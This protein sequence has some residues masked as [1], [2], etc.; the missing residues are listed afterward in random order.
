[1]LHSNRTLTTFVGGLV[2]AGFLAGCSGRSALL[3]IQTAQTTQAAIAGD[4]AE[5]LFAPDACSNPQ[6]LK[7][8][9]KPGGTYKLQITLKCYLGTQ[10]AGCGTTTWSTKL[11]NKLLHAKF[12]NPADPTT[13]TVTA[14]KTIKLGHY[15]QA[16]TVKCTGVP[17]C[18][19]HA[20]G[21]IWV[22]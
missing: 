3:P 5:H 22:I 18:L 14:S 13:E 9:L 8:C 17:N 6:K 16:I 21:A 20:K 4:T 19:F 2:A 11:S 10:Q 1:L 7:I 15:S 12:K